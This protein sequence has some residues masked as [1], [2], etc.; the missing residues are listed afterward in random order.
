MA[1]MEPI[2]TR[3]MLNNRDVLFGKKRFCLVGFNYAFNTIRLYMRPTQGC[4]QTDVLS[5]NHKTKPA[6]LFR[7]L[8]QTIEAHKKRNGTVIKKNTQKEKAIKDDSE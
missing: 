3:Q 4:V 7:L 8:T 1:Q 6:V 2:W 5:G